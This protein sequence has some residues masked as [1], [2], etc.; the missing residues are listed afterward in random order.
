ME[1]AKKLVLDTFVHIYSQLTE[2]RDLAD[3]SFDD[4]FAQTAFP[5]IMKQVEYETSRSPETNTMDFYFRNLPNKDQKVLVLEHIFNIPISKISI[6][7]GM[8]Q[9]E[10]KRVSY[11]VKRDFLKLRISEPGTQPCMNTNDLFSYVVE[12]AN[13]ESI[14]DHLEFCPSCRERLA[15][16]EK[17]LK[18]LDVHLHPVVDGTS[19]QKKILQKLKPYNKHGKK[20]KSWTYQLVSVVAIFIIFFGF[21]YFLPLLNEWKTLASNYMNHGEFYNVWERGTYIATDKE[22]G[23]EIINM[24]VTPLLSRID[25]VIDTE[26]ELNKEVLK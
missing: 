18:T 10:A 13:L 9:E 11:D 15:Q 2:Y 25:Y 26:R 20:T 4:W 16:I 14:E 5:Y 12:G 19:Y 1:R 22:I 3:L 21:I 8:E 23:F 24:E 6:L 7:L 17:E